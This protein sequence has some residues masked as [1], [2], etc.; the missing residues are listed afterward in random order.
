MLSRIIKK[1]VYIQRIEE[2][3]SP[4]PA[5]D[6]TLVKR[7][8]DRV[9]PSEAIGRMAQPGRPGSTVRSDRIDWF[10]EKWRRVQ[11]LWFKA[12]T[13]KISMKLVYIR[14]V[15]GGARPSRR[16]CPGGKCDSRGC[17][18]KREWEWEL[19][20]T[21]IQLSQQSD[22]NWVQKDEVEEGRKM[23]ENGGEKRE[24]KREKLGVKKKRGE[25]EKKSWS[26]TL[27]TFE[28]PQVGFPLWSERDR[29]LQL[30]QYIKYTH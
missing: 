15:G 27:S 17:A 30:H 5:V 21:K 13:K 19:F 4:V 2:W 28:H 12:H 1:K 3:N 20:T 26:D 18:Q 7:R 22:S 9:T 24:R 16:S 25:E 11:P 10:E 8:S 29:K 6:E 14:V 23:D